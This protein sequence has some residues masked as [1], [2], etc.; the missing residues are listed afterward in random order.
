MS[1][2]AETMRL[3][4]KTAAKLEKNYTD[5]VKEINGI[6]PK[7]KGSPMYDET[8]EKIKNQHE[9]ERQRIATEAKA[10]FEKQVAQMR[11]NL[12]NRITK[13][14]NFQQVATMQM[15]HM[16]D[17]ITPRELQLYA[18]QMADC[19]LALK[20]FAQYAAKQNIKITTPD[21]DALLYAV[22]VIES[23]LAAL[24]SYTGNE[25]DSPASVRTTLQ[26]FRSDGDYQNMSS[27]G[28]REIDRKFWEDIVQ[29][30]TPEML[31]ASGTYIPADP[32]YYFRD[33]DEMLQ[34]M[35]KAT[36]G[37]SDKAADDKRSEILQNSPGNYGAAYRYYKASGEK[38]PL[39]DDNE[40]V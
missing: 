11:D 36:E 37:L 30:G 10:A 24:C 29:I 18:A 6:N 3:G 28:T 13:A 25:A 26:Y 17:N 35:D 15:L 8:V 5:S 9:T 7:L 1:L 23:H 40:T 31:D 33:I 39:H 12:N 20:A 19:P 4:R 21:A 32:Q 38:L 2:Y 14:P 16:V 27:A 22:E 34:Y